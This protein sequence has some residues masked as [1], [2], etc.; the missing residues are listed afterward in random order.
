MGSGYR[1][2]ASAAGSLTVGLGGIQRSDLGGGGGVMEHVME[3][4]EMRHQVFPEGHLGGAVV[5]TYTRLQANVQVQLVVGVVL[6]PGHL[7]EAVGLGVDELG[8]LWHWLVGI[9]TNTAK[10]ENLSTNGQIRLEES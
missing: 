7:L 9:P 4:V 8:V 1:R 5:I 10:T 6:G 3:V 2:P